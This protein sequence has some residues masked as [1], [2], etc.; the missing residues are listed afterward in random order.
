M[1]E[2]YLDNHATTRVDPRVVDA[3]IPWMTQEYGNAGSHTHEIGRRAAAMVEESTQAI[4]GLLGAEN[5]DLIFTSGATESIHLAMFGTMTHPRLS[6]RGLLIGQAEH[7]AVLDCGKRLASQGYEVRYLPVETQAVKEIGAVQLSVLEH[8]LH[9]QIGLVCLILGNN[10]IGTFQDVAP[11]ARACHRVGALLHI[12]ATQAVGKIP[13]DVDSSEADFVSF[14]A[15]KFY[16]PKGV[17]GLLVPKRSLKLAP[18]IVGGGQQNNL[19][20]G[21]LNTTGILGMAV[22]LQ[23]AVTEL[24]SERK[25]VEGMRNLLW[26]RLSS[27]IQ[28]LELNGPWI[29]SS[30]TRDAGGFTTGGAWEDRRL[31]GNLNV[32]FPGVEGQAIMLRVPELALSSGSACSSADPRPSHVLQAIGLSEDAARSSLRFGIGRFNTE[33]EIEV[34]AERIVEAYRELRAFIA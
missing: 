22:A 24:E 21:T 2:I 9:E 30:S 12:D 33:A 7:R 16:G 23:I 13:L 32:R 3:M 25:R 17:G 6:K 27:E 11:L 4:L 15:H 20:S 28:G 31:P 5:H 19:R 14:S 18:Q 26:E 34:V 8:S 10:E 1:Q 29:N